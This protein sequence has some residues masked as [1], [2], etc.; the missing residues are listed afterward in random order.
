MTSEVL[1]CKNFEHLLPFKNEQFLGGRTP[2]IR[3]NVNRAMRNKLGRFPNDK[4]AKQA[5]GGYVFPG[6]PTSSGKS[7]DVAT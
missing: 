2:L 1:A 4:Q 3:C 6:S 7:R 5:A